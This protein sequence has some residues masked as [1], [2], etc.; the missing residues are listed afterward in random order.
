MKRWATAVLLA[1]FCCSVYASWQKMA[2]PPVATTAKQLDVTLYGEVNETSAHDTIEAIQA[3]NKVKTNAPI[4][5]YIDSPGGSVIWG[6]LIV[7]AIEGSRRPVWTVN[8]NI[9]A[10]M[11]AI[12]YTYGA[13][14]VMFNH[15]ILMFHNASGGFSGTVPEAGSQLAMVQRLFAGYERHIAEQ[16]KLTIEELR[17][18]E[19]ENW[20]LL[21]DE[22]MAAHLA[23]RTSS[24][25]AFPVPKQ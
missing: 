8:V 9:A 20:W 15:A 14:R 22:A 19:S 7:D 25:G 12:I 18:K 11:A 2:L 17:A 3:A 4:M 1:L 16:A 24:A 5:L 23:D 21:A 13:Q 10:S 6:G